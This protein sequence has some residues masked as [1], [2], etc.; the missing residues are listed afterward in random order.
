M[1]II[2]YKALLTFESVDKVLN[3][4]RLGPGSLQGEKGERAGQKRGR[5]GTEGEK[6]Q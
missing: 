3:C 2:H 1:F 5:W 4:V 6:Q